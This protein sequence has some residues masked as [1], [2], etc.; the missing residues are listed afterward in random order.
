MNFEY[1]DGKQNFDPGEDRILNPR[2]KYFGLE[3]EKKREM[4]K[5]KRERHACKAF[6]VKAKGLKGKNKKIRRRKKLNGP[7]A[8]VLQKKKKTKLK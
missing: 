8:H 4:K 5:K 7:T 1:F 3:I 6:Y 2:L